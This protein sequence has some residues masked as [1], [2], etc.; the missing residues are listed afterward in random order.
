MSEVRR[1]SRQDGKLSELVELQKKIAEKVV[2]RDA[3][4]IDEI[5]F[6]IGVDQAFFKV[7]DKEFVVSAAVLLS[8]PDLRFKESSVDVREVNFPYIPT[9]L[10]FREGDSAIEAVR[11]VLR[12]RT[13]II[14]D[15]SGIAHPRRCGLAT[16]VGV[17][18]ENPSIGVT[19]KPL[20]GSFDEPKRS[21]ESSEIRNGEHIGYAYK[22]CA[23]CNPI[24]VSP[25]NLITPRTALEVVK[26]TIRNY[27]LPI[28]IR[29]AHRLANAEKLNYLSN[30][31][32]S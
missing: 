15:G 18:L 27:K 7:A 26:M 32:P 12:E 30:L 9:F 21:G 22:P 11:K 20:Y 10:M 4:R 1:F 28:P 24:F 19:K 17:E 8:F 6:V 14:V 25:G 5:K 2:L 29:E 13:V 3:M 16:Y 23:R 31:D